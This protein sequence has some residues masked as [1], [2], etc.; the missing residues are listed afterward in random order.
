MTTFSQALA[1]KEVLEI[2]VNL[3]SVLLNS[4]A[5]GS[6]GLTPDDVKFSAAFKQASAAF[7]Q[8]NNELRDYNKTFL[9]TFKNEYRDHRN[10]KRSTS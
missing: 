10:R 6:N 3:T 9:K 8:A 2:N 1:A 5:S 7:K 4:Y